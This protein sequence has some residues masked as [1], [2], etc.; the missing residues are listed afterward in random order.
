MKEWF[1]APGK[2]IGGSTAKMLSPDRA[3]GLAMGPKAKCV[4]ASPSV[5]RAATSQRTIA[6]WR[7]APLPIECRSLR[8]K[9]QKLVLVH[10]GIAAPRGSCMQLGYRT[11]DKGTNHVSHY[12]AV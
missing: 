10:L 9:W 8:V 1:N 5:R 6:A 4:D 7:S 2:L 12:Y 11:P 3:V